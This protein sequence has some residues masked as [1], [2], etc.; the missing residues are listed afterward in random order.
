M[1]AGFPE[2]LDKLLGC[3]TVSSGLDLTDRAQLMALRAAMVIRA[4]ELVRN[5]RAPRPDPEDLVQE[6][7]EEILKRVA[8][9]AVIEN[10]RAYA[11]RALSNRLI[12][13]LRKA[14]FE[15]TLP[16]REDDDRPALDLVAS[17]P[18]DTDPEIADILAKLPPRQRDFL[19]KWVFEGLKINAAQEAAGWPEPLGADGRPRKPY[20][21]VQ[22]LLE[23][24]AEMMGETRPSKSRKDS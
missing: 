23:R 11:Y 9:G 6:V 20:Y 15:G 18:A 3:V 14:K 7:F 10:P 12:S 24:V 8:E 16:Q 2:R 17:R 5:L 1:L 19:V 13:R 22:L 21:E 4:G